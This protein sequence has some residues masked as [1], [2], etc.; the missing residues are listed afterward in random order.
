MTSTVGVQLGPSAVESVLERYRDI[1]IARL[2]SD[3]PECAE[4]DLYRLVRAYPSR[5]GKGLR[6][7]L[8]LAVCRALG[9]DI[10]KAIDSA[11]AIE[12]THN[13]FLILD[14]I[15]DGSEMRRGAPTLPAEYGLGVA[16]N[17]GNATNL[18]ALQHLMA[19][20]WT[21]GPNL[22][23]AVLQESALMMRHSLEGQAI[24]VGWIRNNACDLA[25]DDYYRMCMKKSSW[26]T[27][28]Y[29]CRVGALVAEGQHK[30]TARFDRYGCYLGAAF[31]IQ[32]DLLNLTGHYAQYGKEISGDLWEGKRTLVLIEYMRRCTGA[33]RARMERFLGKTRATRTEAEVQWVHDELLASGCV[34]T[35]RARARSLAEEAHMEALE[36]F[37]GHPDSEE[38]QFLLDLPFYMVERES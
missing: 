29:P 17:V 15:Q 10:E 18:L 34:E 12:L 7:A 23:W 20:R 13:A 35:V 2:M 27:C 4:D 24:E 21:L 31:Q 8:C 38:K 28:I 1:T 33:Q 30:H 3:I 22:A 14:D 11:V 6:P 16:V 32:D 37:D 19:N 9:G 26:Y 36:A 25:D 5:S